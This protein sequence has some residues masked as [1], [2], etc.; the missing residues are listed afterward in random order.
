MPSD[1]KMTMLYFKPPGRVGVSRMI[2]A[3]AGV[4]FND[5]RIEF[6]TLDP[7]KPTLPYKQ[8]P[9]LELED[10]TVLG[11]SMAIARYLANRYNL[12]GNTAMAK[13]EADE[14][15]DALSDIQTKLFGIFLAEDKKSKL[16]EVLPAI[17]AGFKNLEARLE[18]RGG[19]HLAGNNTTWADLH[20]NAIIA[21]LNAVGGADALKGCPKL[22][23]L[24]ERVE[25]IPNI[26]KYNADPK[27]KY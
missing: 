14:A 20:L 25:S 16:T 17:E 26:K 9:T 11:Q 23:N 7:L 10:G 24:N 5:K 12:A 15:V 4:D 2:L 1:K 3:Y 6:G 13:A 18:L 22:K 19:Q 8:A 27:N 21:L